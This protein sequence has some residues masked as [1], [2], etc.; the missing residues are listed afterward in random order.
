LLIGI[1]AALG[2]SQVLR[3]VLFGVNP[4]DPLALV[5]AAVV[6]LSLAALAAWIPAHRAARVDPLIALRTE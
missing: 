6:V 1:P 3:G 4:H 2:L 5:T